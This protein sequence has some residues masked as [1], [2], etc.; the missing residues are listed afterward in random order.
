MLPLALLPALAPVLTC[1]AAQA[2][3]KDGFE[4]VKCGADIPKAL[5]GKKLRNE[6]VV[7]TEARR[8]ALKLKDLGADQVTDT[9]NA[10]HWSICGVEH[11]MLTE[12][13]TILD[14]IALPPVSAAAPRFWTVSCKTDGK[15]L[16]GTVIGA[17]DNQAGKGEAVPLPAK[18][19]WKLDEKSRK[20]L[21]LP[22]KGL[23]CPRG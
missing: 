8:A 13:S 1:G 3:V 10:I 19:A 7:Q 5:L 16:A 12:R 21:P 6:P 22:V 2:Q 23:V 18:L 9:L 11:V 15:P 4:A 20:F 14:V 17:L